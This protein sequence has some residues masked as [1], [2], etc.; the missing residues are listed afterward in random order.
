MAGKPGPKVAYVVLWLP[1]PSQTFVLNEVNTLS[2]LGLDLEV[3][4]L[5]GPRSSRRVAGL[6]PVQPPVT[7]FGSR[8]LPQLLQNL[9]HLPSRFGS[10]AA[11][12]LRTVLLRRWRSLETAGE[13][14]WAALAGVH[15]ARLLPARG[16]QH[17][18]ASWANGPAT[19]AWV[20]SHLSGIP[21]SFCA[22]A[23]DIYPPDGALLEKLAAAAFVRTENDANRHYLAGLLPAAAPKLHT[24]YNG[25]P[26]QVTKTVRPAFS[27][28]YNLLALG[29]FVVKKGFADLLQACRLLA[30]TGLDF[31]LTLAGDGPEK[32]HLQEL[33]DRYQLGAR[34]QLPGF[35]DHHQV[36]RLMAAAHLFVMPSIVAPSGD[37]DGTPT[38]IAEALLHQVPVV[39]T[40]VCGIPEMVRPGETGW[41]VPPA[42]PPALAAAITQ[43]L[44]DPAEA[45]RRAKNG[46]RLMREQFD[47]RKNYRRLMSCFAGPADCR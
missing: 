38:V 1:E 25:V 26:L 36:T 33:V 35:V 22:R 41:L 10:E 12:F 42:D 19:A 17:I 7:R 27:P 20:A 34:V 18:H 40:Q 15:L 32:A 46:S 44:A 23:H 28:P 37:R 5:Y 6:P 4:T 31:Q 47:S 30:Q 45:R 13:A 11:P 14:L 2:G 29:R 24:V 3:F 43:A 21:F 39:A 8:C 9:T 16:A